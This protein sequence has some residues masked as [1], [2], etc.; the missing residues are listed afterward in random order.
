MLLSFSDKAV[1]I[2]ALVANIACGIANYYVGGAKGY[3]TGTFNF[4]VCA[5]LIWTARRE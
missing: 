3:V 5:F 2:I 1:V 4:I